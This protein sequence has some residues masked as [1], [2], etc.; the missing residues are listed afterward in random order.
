MPEIPGVVTGHV[1]VTPGCRSRKGST[2]AFDEAISILRQEY[3]DCVTD[4]RNDAVD[5][6]LSISIE[7]KCEHCSCVRNNPGAQCCYCQLE[8]TRCLS[9]L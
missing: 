9:L 6:H 3:H 2:K 4:S 1:I 5:Y 8:G 7:R